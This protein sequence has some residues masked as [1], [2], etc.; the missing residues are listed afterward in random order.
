VF[1]CCARSGRCRRLRRSRRKLVALGAAN[2]SETWNYGV[3]PADCTIHSS[4]D[5]TIADYDGDGTTDV[6][7]TTT[8]EV[9]VAFGAR[10]GTE[11]LRANLSDYGYTRPIVAD[12]TG[13]G[14]REIVVV[15]V[16]GKVFVLRPDGSTA[17]TRSFSLY[18][19]AQPAVADFDA[20]GGP[21]LAVGFVGSGNLSL[22]NGNGTRQWTLGA[23]VSS[24]ITWMTTG[25]A[26]SDDAIEV[27]VATDRGTVAAVDGASGEIE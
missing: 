8:E 17:W 4:A 15:D 18:T 22:L 16:Q 14:A 11:E 19:N 25:Q 6:L 5:P 9:V 12:L 23:P 27:V 2:G 10:T 21:E 24:S 13:D 26:D 7:A 1:R 3:P 20:D